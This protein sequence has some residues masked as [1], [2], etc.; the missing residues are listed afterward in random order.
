MRSSPSPSGV[1]GNAA[2]KQ[3]YCPIA[4]ATGVVRVQRAVPD[5][6]PLPLPIGRGLP[7]RSAAPRHFRN[8]CYLT[9]CELR[10]AGRFRVRT[11]FSS[12]THVPASW[13]APA[14]RK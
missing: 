10:A 11:G 2:T 13:S 14:R 12:R 5:R 7:E 6:G 9:Q 1:E 4:G 8:Q 3:T